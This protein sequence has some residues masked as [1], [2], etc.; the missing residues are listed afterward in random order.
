VDTGDLAAALVHPDTRRRF[1]TILSD[2]DLT[3]I[4]DA[5]LEKWR[6]FLH[7]SQEKLVAKKFN[8][9]A[10]VTG[11][12]GTGN[13]SAKRTDD[14]SHRALLRPNAGHQRTRADHS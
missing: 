4:L 6:V 9:P 8:G 12:A 10:K 2:K 7:P 11:G 14:Q 5:P 13:N 3:S 1:V